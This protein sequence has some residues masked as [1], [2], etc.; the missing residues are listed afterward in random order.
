[1]LPS[2]NESKQAYWNQV[3]E[4]MKMH[5]ET[6]KQWREKAKAAL[7]PEYLVVIQSMSW[8]GP[9]CEDLL[10]RLIE[11]RDS[12]FVSEEDF[13]ALTTVQPETA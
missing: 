11:A 6:D 4:F 12:G 8:N 3:V 5:A 9:Y 1:M 13:M 10:D 7:P 2:D